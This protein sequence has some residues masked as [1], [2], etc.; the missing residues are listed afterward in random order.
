LIEHGADVTVDK[1][2]E[3]DG[4]RWCIKGN[5]LVLATLLG[6]KYVKRLYI[7]MCAYLCRLFI[8]T[9]YENH[10][11]LTFIVI[12]FRHLHSMQQ[13]LHTFTINHIFLS[14]LYKK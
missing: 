7:H 1:R 11:A 3:D 14:G 2:Y 12:Q 8:L 13:L 9:L 10:V 5:C 6:Q 4:G